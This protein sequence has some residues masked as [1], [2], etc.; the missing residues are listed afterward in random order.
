MAMIVLL[1]LLSA[2]MYVGYDLIRAPSIESEIVKHLLWLQFLSVF[3]RIIVFGIPAALIIF[4]GYTTGDKITSTLSGVFLIPIFDIYSSIL[5][6]LLD[7]DFIMPSLHYWLS[8]NRLINLTPPMLIYGLMGY[9]ASRRT[10]ASLVV[11]ISIGIL[12]V[13]LFLGID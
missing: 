9:F 13:L 7:P 1:P 12:M 2:L 8:W 5:F 10:K 11:A 6:E 3:W 4:Y